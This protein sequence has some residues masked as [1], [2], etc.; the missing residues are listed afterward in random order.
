M[1]ANA[2]A[3]RDSPAACR[4]RFAVAQVAPGL[5]FHDQVVALPDAVAIHPIITGPPDQ[6]AFPVGGI[7]QEVRVYIEI[8]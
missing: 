6:A 7:A 2:S 4:A 8:G 1:H 5:F 3:R